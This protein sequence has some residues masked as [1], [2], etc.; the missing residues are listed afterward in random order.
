MRVYVRGGPLVTLRALADAVEPEVTVKQNALKFGSVF[1]GSVTRKRVTLRNASEVYASLKCDLRPFPE[2]DIEL[3]NENWNPEDYDDPPV[4][5]VPK[6]AQNPFGNRALN[7]MKMKSSKKIMESRGAEDKGGNLYKIAVAPKQE[8]TF[9]LVFHPSEASGAETFALPML[10]EGVARQ[11]DP[12][13]MCKPVSC[14]GVEPRIKFSETVINFGQKIILR[15]G[16]RK[17][18]YVFEFTVSHNAPAGRRVS[19]GA[20]ANPR[21]CPRRRPRTAESWTSARCSRLNR[22]WASSRRASRRR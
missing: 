10:L 18:P 5:R 17:M 4:L 13:R 8:L 19:T 15:E 3:P 14:N 16:Y 20:S 21:T 6:L 7:R 11:P 1:V 2:F 12:E 22:G 9:H